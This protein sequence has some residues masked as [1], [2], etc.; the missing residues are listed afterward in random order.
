MSKYTTVFGAPPEGN[1]VEGGVCIF[2]AFFWGLTNIPTKKPA[3]RNLSG[4]WRQTF[5]CF[6]LTF[7]QDV[8]KISLSLCRSYIVYQVNRIII[9][10]LWAGEIVRNLDMMDFSLPFYRNFCFLP[11]PVREIGF[12][13]YFT[14]F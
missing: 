3:N 4:G 13:A 7:P 11:E 8:T 10:H 14:F 2:E 6:S 5:A 9:F 12:G 1:K